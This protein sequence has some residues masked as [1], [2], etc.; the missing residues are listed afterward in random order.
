MGE[1]YPFI[2]GHFITGPAIY[3]FQQ[4]DLLINAWTANVIGFILAIEGFNIVNGWETPSET[5]SSGET[6][7]ALKP[8]HIPGDIS[9][10]PLNLGP[11]SKE[12]F[13][14]MQTRE[15]NNGRLAMISVTGL[16]VQGI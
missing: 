6:F 14:G 7:A 5:F 1:K 10:D 16:I 2:V 3:H 13:K 9:F 15:L 4:A 11:M 8:N 12:N